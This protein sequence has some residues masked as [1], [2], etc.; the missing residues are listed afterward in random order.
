MDIGYAG[1]SEF[2][3]SPVRTCPD[4]PKVN[5]ESIHEPCQLERINEIFEPLYVG[6]ETAHEQKD[7]TPSAG[8]CFQGTWP[9]SRK[10]R[11]LVGDQLLTIE[12]QQLPV[13]G[14]C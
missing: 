7:D 1:T 5:V 13:S 12:S 6:Y 2:K 8:W 10:N 3:D 9:F 11:H 4:N 14:I